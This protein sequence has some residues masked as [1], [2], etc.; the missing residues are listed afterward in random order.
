MGKVTNVQ[1]DKLECH[2]VT[3]VLDNITHE[4]MRNGQRLY[5]GTSFTIDR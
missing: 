3:A 1:R 4:M 5:G 2:N